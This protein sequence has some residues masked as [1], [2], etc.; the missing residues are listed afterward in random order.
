[1][2]GLY[3]RLARGAALA[4]AAALLVN[5]PLHAQPDATPRVVSGIDAVVLQPA[6]LPL[7]SPVRK[8]GIRRVLLELFFDPPFA[9]D[10]YLTGTTEQFGPWNPSLFKLEGGTPYLRRVAVEVPASEEFRFKLTLGDWTRQQIDERGVQHQDHQ[11]PVGTNTYTTTVKGFQGGLD[12]A[13]ES[14]AEG[15]VQGRLELLRDV[16][17]RSTINPR[18]VLVWLPTAYDAAPA[19]R[20][21][22]LYM[23]DGQNLFDPR[24]IP[25][26]V[27][28]GVDE[29]VERLV[30]Q[31]RMEP[32][33]VVGAFNS[34]DRRPE[35]SPHH[36]AP[37]Y[38]DFLMEELKPLIDTRYRTLP[39]REHTAVMGSSMGGL[40][41]LY[42][43]MRHPDKV[44]RLGCVST[45]WVWEGGKMVESL[46]RGAPIPRNLRIYFDF[47]T[48][49]VD[50]PY[51]ALQGRVDAAMAAQ[52]WSAGREV[53]TRRFEGADHNEAAWRGRLDA[54]L[55]DLYGMPLE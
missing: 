40:V 31:G 42:T 6:P 30:S 33:I 34:P 52:G 17:S 32:V 7:D 9:G 44:S 54:I 24:M 49:G 11:V 18:H 35:Y 16:R 47:G 25:S 39:G 12:G 51:A 3:A 36:K 2:E 8:Q 37:E 22:V 13:L 20:F 19:R 55:V 41:S 38:A 26:G 48:V 5:A 27:D 50:A 45:H 10:V 53:I 43:G 15:G 21:P 29:A 4:L 46:E 23:H 1:M 28:W 14:L